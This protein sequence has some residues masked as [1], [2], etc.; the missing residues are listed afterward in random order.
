[1]EKH[2]N[3]AKIENNDL[4]SEVKKK[5]EKLE[6]STSW[7]AKQL[8]Y[9]TEYLRKLLTKKLKATEP[10]LKAFEQFKQKLE[11]MEQIFLPA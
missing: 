3:T 11:K 2:E 4:I 6:L 9:T 5:L 1:M 8:G 7:A 10:I